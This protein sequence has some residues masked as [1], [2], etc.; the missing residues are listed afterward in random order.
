MIEI[1]L[2]RESDIPAAMELKEFAGWNQTENDWRTLLKLEPEGCFAAVLNGQLVGT[3]TTTCYGRELAWIGMVLVRPEQ[4]R[5]GIATKLMTTALDYLKPKVATVK[6][7]ATSQG[8]E[9]YEKLGFQVESRVERWG[10]TGKAETVANDEVTIV[11]TLDS[12]SRQELLL[13]DRHAFGADRSKLLETLISNKPVPPVLVR[14]YDG[15]LTGYALLRTGSKA[16]YI[17]PV[18][19]SESAQIGLLLDGALS[20]LGS[21]RVYVDF[22]PGSVQPGILVTRGFV[23]EREFIRMSWGRASEKTSS[24]VFAIAGPEIG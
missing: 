5:S 24:F 22:N 11:A 13:L 20:Q 18:V 7:D 16:A 9:V 10:G 12:K 23:K 1:R 17:G 2:L 8:K 19:T 21:Q 6:L 4:R 14:S 15:L 3:T